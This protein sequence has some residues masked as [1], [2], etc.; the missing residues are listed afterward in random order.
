MA[1]L[2]VDKGWI[3]TASGERRRASPDVEIVPWSDVATG[4][5]D[6]GFGRPQREKRCAPISGRRERLG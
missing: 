4:A 1:D 5:A 2:G 6:F 3:V